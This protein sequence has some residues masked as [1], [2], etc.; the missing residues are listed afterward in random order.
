[1]TQLIG[2]V[3]GNYKIIIDFN[4]ERVLGYNRHAP[5]PWVVWRV[6]RN[7][8]MYWGKYFGDSA[9]AKNCFIAA[10][11]DTRFP[12]NN[13]NTIRSLR[14]EMP[15]GYL[16]LTYK[17]DT[18]TY[19]I[20]SRNTFDFD[21]DPHRALKAYLRELKTCTSKQVFEILNLEKM[22]TES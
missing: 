8:D 9:E 20:S 22:R 5:Q 17:E 1:M 13:I 4:N 16:T 12:L 10:V 21:T 15:E 7:G 6:D 19:D 11:R 2:K 3:V 18:R 14:T